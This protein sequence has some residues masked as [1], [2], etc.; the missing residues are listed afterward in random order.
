M[1]MQMF[2]GGTQGN[3][4]P[5][6]SPASSHSP[7]RAPT[8]LISP[9]ESQE[10]APSVQSNALQRSLVVLLVSSLS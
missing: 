1:A 3:P 8:S 6:L 5:L 4:S 2:P 7:F 10:A 9:Q